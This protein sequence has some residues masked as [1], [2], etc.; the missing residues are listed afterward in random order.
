MQPDET[1]APIVSGSF[2]PWGNLALVAS[3]DPDAWFDDTMTILPDYVTRSAR[4]RDDAYPVCHVD[5]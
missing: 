2:E 5:A 3:T 4:I 1:A